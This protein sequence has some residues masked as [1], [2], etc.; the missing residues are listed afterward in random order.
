[1]ILPRQPGQASAP[2][3]LWSLLIAFGFQIGGAGCSK[4]G[5]PGLPYPAANDAG[6]SG[7][8]LANLCPAYADIGFPEISR[9]RPAASEVRG[10]GR[11]A[12]LIAIVHGLIDIGRG[13]ASLRARLGSQLGH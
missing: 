6:V 8:M 1:M 12:M 5:V 3:A 7:V 10:S 11:I 4:L 13:K 9:H 2:L